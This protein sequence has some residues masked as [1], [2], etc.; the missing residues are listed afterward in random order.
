MEDLIQSTIISN[1]WC[2]PNQNKQFIIKPS[3][4]T[5]PSGV[6]GIIN[7]ALLEISMPNLSDVFH[8]FNIGQLHP[9][10]LNLFYLQNRYL[11]SD[12]YLLGDVMNNS[13]V[14]IDIYTTNG[15]QI[16]RQESYYYFNY[17]KDLIVAIK[18]NFNIPINYGSDDIYLRVYSNSY[19]INKINPN[20]LVNSK[21]NATAQDIQNIQTIYQN[22]LNQ[23][24]Y[25]LLFINGLLVNDFNSSTINVGDAIELV[26]D[27]SIYKVIDFPLSGLP[28]FL[29]TVYNENRYLLHYSG[30]R[31]NSIDYFGDTDLY[32]QSIYNN[33][34]CGV[35]YHKNTID[36]CRNITHQDYSISVDRVSNF[37]TGLEILLNQQNIPTTSIFLRL[38]IRTTSNNGRSLQYENNRISSLYL[39][40]D[41][42]ITQTMLSTVSGPINW[43]VETL[44]ASPYIT[45][46]DIDYRQITDSLGVQ[47]YGYNALS[48]L[49]GNTPLTTTLLSSFEQVDLP[50]GL[51]NN[52]TIYEYDINGLLL[53]SYPH[54]T[55]VTYT[56]VNN[57]TKL[58]EGIVG[59]GSNTPNVL[60]GTNNI[61]LPLNCGYRVYKCHYILDNNNNPT[62][63]LDNIWT[64]ITNNI[65]NYTVV[66]NVL[67]WVGSDT[68]RFLMVR[69][70]NSFLD[71]D[72]MI[73]PNLG[74]L[75][76]NLTEN[77]DRGNGLN[78]Y[79]LPI[80]LGQLDIF[81]NSKS[82]IEN[83][84]YYVNFPTI[85]IINTKYLMS[86]PNNTQQHIHVRF[87]GFCNNN[88]QYEIPNDI[89]FIQYGALSNNNHYDLRT[90]KVLRILVDGKLQQLSNLTFIETTPTLQFNSSLN[91]LPYMVRDLV[92]PMETYINQDTYAFRS[93]SQTIDT[94]VSS[95]LSSIFPQEPENNSSVIITK[96]NVYS[97][98]IY[99]IVCFIL[100]NQITND[101]ISSLLSDSDIIN[102]CQQFEHLLDSDPTHKSLNTFSPFLNILPVNTTA[103]VIN[104]SNLQYTF[105]NNV[106]RLYCNNLLTLS[107]YII[108]GG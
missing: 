70:D 79:S 28:V 62:T 103:S 33:S 9:S 92:V 83:I 76:F 23:T 106:V 21:I 44:E 7:I 56:C 2:D 72:F 3:R 61:T 101:D 102:F 1:I 57:T 14:Y 49:L 104:L 51:Q 94:N 35:L 88:L 10:I 47:L 52:S 42:A 34:R 74:V 93:L 59:M 90:D 86:N 54:L 65:S 66:N 78:S 82:L 13:N 75:A 80:P 63:V 97:P 53:G 60:F 64:D 22:L 108:N 20:I 50:L 6:I 18:E 26:Y 4:L 55:G 25:V 27:K 30:N 85:T 68:N 41:Q 40:N 87:T 43:R 71:L 91:G 38:F 17:N 81:L 24:G 36:A 37:L 45:A 105:L 100:L 12:W 98:F 29:S 58:I 15:V 8:L 31:A 96:Y 73:T 67:N 89:G 46:M 99:N 5:L 16:P 39:M 95:Y 107:P 69:T 19:F 32:I 48:V 11:S 77:E 84:D